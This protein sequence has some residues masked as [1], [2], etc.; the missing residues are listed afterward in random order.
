MTQACYG[1]VVEAQG[2]GTMGQSVQGQTVEGQSVEGQ[3]R[4]TML[5][6]C[7]SYKL[8]QGGLSRHKP[9]KSAF[10]VT[11]NTAPLKQVRKK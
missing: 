8:L 2:K 10:G 9:S 1:Q 6:G 7:R 11:G 3:G 4:G 5:G